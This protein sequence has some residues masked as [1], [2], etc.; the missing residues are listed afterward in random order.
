[1]GQAFFLAA[2]FLGAAAFFSAFGAA[3]AVTDA[4]SALRGLRT[5]Y[6]PLWIFPLLDLMSPLPMVLSVFGGLLSS[7]AILRT[8][9]FLLACMHQAK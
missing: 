2:A 1:V 8:L 6:E 7:A 3:T 9:V 4:A 5:P